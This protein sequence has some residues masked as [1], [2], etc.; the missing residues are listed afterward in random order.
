[1]PA[2]HLA[3]I[4]ILCLP[5]SGCSIP[6]VETSRIDSEGRVDVGGQT[7]DFVSR[8]YE[9][10]TVN[11]VSSYYQSTV[12]CGQQTFQCDDNVSVTCVDRI[13]AALGRS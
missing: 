1:M 10:P 7:C 4:A 3:A 6:G 11:G 5:L 9:T 8:I 13:A 2:R 12:T